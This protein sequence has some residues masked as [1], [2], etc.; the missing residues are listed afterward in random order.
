MINILADQHLYKLNQFNSPSLDVK[1]YDPTKPLPDLKGFNAWLLR[2][3]TKVN[4]QTTPNIPASLTFI[5]TGSAGTDHL[6]ENYLREK[7]IRVSNA[8]GCNANAVAEYVITA[9]LLLRESKHCDFTK[10]KIGIIGVGAVGSA[11]E[12]ILRSF[13]CEL[14]LYD[15]PRSER[16]S[17]FQSAS[18]NEVLSCDIL[19]LHVPY[20]EEGNYPTKY[21]LN[22]S[23]LL[24]HSFDVVIN[25]ARGGV[26]NEQSLLDAYRRKSV[27][28][29]IIDV[30]ENEPEYNAELVQVCFIATPHVA[31]HSEQSKY[32][33]TKMIMDDLHTFL[34]ISYSSTYKSNVQ[35]IVVEPSETSLTNILGACHP[36]IELDS[37]L[38]RINDAPN[39][40]ALFAKLRTDRPYRF[41]YPFIRLKGID[42]SNYPYLLQ[43]GVRP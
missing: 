37:A 7:D 40:A 26:I 11:V 14:V 18:F 31:G 9:L 24:K 15:P 23:E 20:T 2:T 39:R 25:T 32:L 35:S 38:R 36:M 5:G 10:R 43:L 33:A 42:L 21:L 8:K 28:H 16:E 4:E 3:V 6:D 34:N 22:H 17:T 19:S 29:I 1:L 41:E 12:K 30:W 27:Q 13:G